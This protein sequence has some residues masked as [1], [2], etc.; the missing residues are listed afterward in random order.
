MFS[1]QDLFGNKAKYDG[2]VIVVKGKCVKINKNIMG[3]NWMHI[4]DGTG[5]D[6]PFDLTITTDADVPVGADV[7]MRGKITLD[8]DFG[9]GYHYD[10]I[11]E[12]AKKL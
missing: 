3:R 6:K 5:S 7:S 8:K 9:A 11:M 2:K 1:L 4:Q 12:E 10:I